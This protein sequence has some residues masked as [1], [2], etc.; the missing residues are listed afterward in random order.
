[1]QATTTR[2]RRVTSPSR[3]QTR[4]SYLRAQGMQETSVRNSRV[5]SWSTHFF[6]LGL[7]APSG[8]PDRKRSCRGHGLRGE[9]C[10]NGALLEKR[11]IRVVPSRFSLM[12]LDGLYNGMSSSLERL[13]PV[14]CHTD[15]TLP[16]RAF[17]CRGSSEEGRRKPLFCPSRRR[18]GE[19]R[20]RSVPLVHSE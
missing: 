12:G 11:P 20:R 10:R 17:R 15:P 13:L 5:S 7:S 16:D 18:L 14:P 6:V 3:T 9:R 19:R 2:S 8:N 1:L 4:G